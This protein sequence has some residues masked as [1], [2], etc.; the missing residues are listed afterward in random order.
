MRILCVLEHVHTQTHV[1][2]IPCLTPNK[3]TLMYACMYV[4]MSA[5]ELV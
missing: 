5:L 3:C 2:S 1:H 4:C